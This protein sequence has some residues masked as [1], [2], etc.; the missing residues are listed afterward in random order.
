MIL[1]TETKILVTRIPCRFQCH[2]W[3]RTGFVNQTNEE[4]LNMG[5]AST[6][7]MRSYALFKKTG[8]S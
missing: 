6:L 7:R 3:T 2:V 1:K 5:E 4:S 8:F